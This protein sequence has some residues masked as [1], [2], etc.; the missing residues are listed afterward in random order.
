[1]IDHG[2]DGAV[3]IEVVDYFRSDETIDNTTKTM[4]ISEMVNFVTQYVYDWTI[5]VRPVS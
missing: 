2:Y 3:L 1:L 4:Q 5:T